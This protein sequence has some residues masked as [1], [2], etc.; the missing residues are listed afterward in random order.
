[1]AQAT[2]NRLLRRPGF[3]GLV[4]AALIASAVVV[5][6][7]LNSLIYNPQ[8]PVEDYVTAL[9]DGD[10]PTAMALSQGYLADDAPDT[11]ST[12]LLDGESLAASAAMLHDAQLEVRDAD[13]AVPEQY[14]DPELTQRVVDITFQDH[15]ET[16]HVTSLVV[17]QVGTSWGVFHEWALHPVPL[18]QVAL[19]P[20]RMP[21]Y[22]DDD[23]PVA[24]IHDEATPLLGSGDAPSTLAAFTPA[25]IELD[26]HGT[27]LEVSEPQRFVVTDVL[28]PGASSQFSFD[29]SLTPAVDEAITEEVQEQL[30]RCTDQT[31]LQPAGCPFGY[32]TAN[33]VRPETVSW[34]IDVPDVEYSWDDSDP[35]I[36]W[37]LATAKLSAQ[38]IDIG[39]GEESAVTYEEVFEMSADL[40]L[41]PENIRVRPDWQ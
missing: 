27:Y 34:S 10:G 5:V 29:V 2:T 26:Y 6:S 28:A 9:R 4:A 8:A 1:M 39:T 7:L 17:D 23:A 41:T 30:L 40:E 18:Q 24:R 31:V 37:I 22:S 35:S 11:I 12:V 14:R 25:L 16:Q 20:A 19:D 36:N 13:A 21:E 3:W 33:R 15:D 32:R 38:Q